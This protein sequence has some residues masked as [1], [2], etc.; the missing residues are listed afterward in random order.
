[1]LGGARLAFAGWGTLNRAP[2]PVFFLSLNARALRVFKS[3]LQFSRERVHSRA[4]AFPDTLAL[5][6]YVADTPTPRSNHTANCPIIAAVR[7]FLVK[8][9]HDVR[10]NA[11]EGA[12][13]CG[14]LDAGFA[15]IPRDTQHQ[16]HL[17]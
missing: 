11:N 17:L 12:Q 13:R 3:Q 6:P 5:E 1:M 15:P 14:W 16:R 8:T 9:A 2:R 7:M 4:R 10:R